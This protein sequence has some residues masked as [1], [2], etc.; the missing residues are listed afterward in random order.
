SDLEGERWIADFI[1]TNCTSVCLPM[2]YNMSQLQDRL[3]EEGIDIQLVSFSVDPDYDTPE[4]LRETGESYN[5][6]F[7]NWTLLTRYEFDTIKELSIKS[8]KSPLIEP[9]EGSDQ[10]THGVFF[11]L[12][13][14]DHE[15]IKYYDG[16][17]EKQIDVIISDLKAIMDS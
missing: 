5:A 1:F 12:I 17:D 14:P 15:I 10:V 9:P 6:D 2:T 11:Y 3:N 16:V 4:L 7:R 8:F 13:S